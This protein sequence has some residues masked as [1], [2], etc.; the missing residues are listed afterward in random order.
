MKWRLYIEEYSPELQYIKGTHNVVAGA[1]SRLEINETPI[2]D[3][4][5]TFLGLM[6]CFGLKQP[7]ETDFHPLNFKHLLKTQEND[8]TTMKILAMPN[9][10][11]ELQDFHGGGKTTALIC[12]RN[13]IVVPN[14]L[15]KAGILW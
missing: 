5:E 4:R 14:K 1:L 11:Y 9:T 6:E 7:D 2:Q 10:K 13:K 3:T 15:Q 12:Y 8:K